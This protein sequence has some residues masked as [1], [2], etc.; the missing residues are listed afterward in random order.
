[1]SS[2]ADDV[3][4][5]LEAFPVVHPRAYVRAASFGETRLDRRTGQRVPH[6]AV[7]IGAPAGSVI[8]S[9]TPGRVL[10]VLDDATRECGFGVVIRDRA[11]HRLYTY[12]HMGAIPPVTEGET[13]QPGQLLGYVGSTGRSTGPHLHLKAID[14]RTGERIDLTRDLL[15]LQRIARGQSTRPR[16]GASPAPRRGG[17]NGFFWLLGVAWLLRRNA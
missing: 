2:P 6:G 11:N 8:V 1:M 7:D 12:C 13:V 5:M 16:D 4:P 14:T 10:R 15:D 9:A 17:G 3:G